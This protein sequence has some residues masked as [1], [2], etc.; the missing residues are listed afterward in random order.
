MSTRGSEFDGNARNRVMLGFWGEPPNEAILGLRDPQ[1]RT[2]DQ[3]TERT[4]DQLI[5]S[6]LEPF[7]EDFLQKKP[8]EPG[9]NLGMD[10]G[11]F[12]K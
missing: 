9:R 1:N 2:R 7:G 3:D 4:E 6:I 10:F 5:W 11:F 12:F 8:D